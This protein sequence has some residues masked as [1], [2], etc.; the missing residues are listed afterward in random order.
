MTLATF[1]TMAALFASRDCSI[2]SAAALTTL[3]IA[4]NY[5]SASVLK[6]EGEIPAEIIAAWIS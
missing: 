3:W 4:S 2:K 6:D 1:P 5:R